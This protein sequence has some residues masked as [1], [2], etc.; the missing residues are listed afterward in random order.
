MGDLELSDRLGYRSVAKPGKRIR[1][2]RRGRI[3]PA[4]EWNVR[5]GVSHEEFE[6]SGG[7]PRVVDRAEG[8]DARAAPAQARGSEG[9]FAEVER[10]RKFLRHVGHAEPGE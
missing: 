7:R 1:L 9:G 5:K 8:R 10:A 6:Q 2:R 4:V 3:L